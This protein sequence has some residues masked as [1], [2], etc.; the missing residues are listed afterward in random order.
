MTLPALQQKSVDGKEV[1]LE[2]AESKLKCCSQNALVLDW[3][4]FNRNFEPHRQALIALPLADA[5]DH[6][7]DESCQTLL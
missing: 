3:K 7:F 1:E 6:V 4:G 2:E 5:H